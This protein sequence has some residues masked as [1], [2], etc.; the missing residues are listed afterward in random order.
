M[1]TQPCGRQDYGCNDDIMPGFNMYGTSKCTVTHFSVTPAK[2]LAERQSAVRTGRLSP[3][4][5]V[6][7]FLTNA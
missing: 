5:T 3:G 1:E 6:T 7:D 4:I 2:E